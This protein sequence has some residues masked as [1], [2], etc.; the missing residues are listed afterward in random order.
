MA[1]AAIMNCYLVTLDHPRSLLHGRKSVLE[2]HVNRT[3]LSDRWPLENFEN[4]A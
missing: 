3:I 4:L 2:F 1:A